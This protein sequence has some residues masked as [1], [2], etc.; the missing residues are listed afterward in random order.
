MLR[1]L[2]ESTVHATLILQGS[3]GYKA[4][5]MLLKGIRLRGCQPLISVLSILGLPSKID[6]FA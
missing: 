6:I 5:T 1:A 2:E 4:G 3:Y